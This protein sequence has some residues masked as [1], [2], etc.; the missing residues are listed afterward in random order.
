MTSPNSRL[1]WPNWKT[2]LLYPIVKN[3]GRDI[4]RTGGFQPI[5]EVV[6]ITA[7]GCQS[8]TRRF[9]GNQLGEQLDQW[10]SVREQRGF[11]W[12]LKRFPSYARKWGGS[13]ISEWRTTRRYM[14]F[15]MKVW[16]WEIVNQFSG[17]IASVGWVARQLTWR[18]FNNMIGCKKIKRKSFLKL[19]AS[20]VFI[21]YDLITRR[22]WRLEQKNLS[23]GTNKRVTAGLDKIACELL[24]FF[25]WRYTNFQRK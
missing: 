23:V 22:I 19:I 12:A 6:K 25:S 13:N 21:F 16:K 15:L 7:T 10:D 11:I 17:V 4:D 2:Y 1:G 3:A 20:L 9:L 14:E 18:E 5:R 8:Q 24:T